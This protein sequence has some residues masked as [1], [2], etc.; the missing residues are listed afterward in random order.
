MVKQSKKVSPRISLENATLYLN[1]IL[2][3]ETCVSK[4]DGRVLNV[5]MNDHPHLYLSFM[6]K[7][8]NESKIPFVLTT[9]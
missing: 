3:D 5:I 1:K 2:T 4:I 6:S 7:V 9:D 8:E